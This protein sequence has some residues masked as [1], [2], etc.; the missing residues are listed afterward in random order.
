MDPAEALYNVPACMLRAISHSLPWPVVF[1]TMIMLMVLWVVAGVLVISYRVGC[2]IVVLLAYIRVLIVSD[3]KEIQTAWAGELHSIPPRCVVHQ[4]LD[5]HAFVLNPVL[6][7][8]GW[9]LV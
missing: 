8:L 3:C 2:G 9:L 6:S 1:W 5:G 4:A 7:L